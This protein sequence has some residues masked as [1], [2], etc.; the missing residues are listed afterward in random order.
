MRRVPPSLQREQAQ[1]EGPPSGLQRRSKTLAEVRFIA[2][3]LPSKFLTIFSFQTLAL[4]L[5]RSRLRPPSPSSLPT[6]AA[7]RCLMLPLA[8]SHALWCPLPVSRL[9]VPSLAVS[10]ALAPSLAVSGAPSPSLVH[11]RRP[12]SSLVPCRRTSCPLP[13][14]R[15][16]TPSRAVPRRPSRSG[17]VSGYLWCFLVPSRRLSSSLVPPHC[18]S[19][20]L[21]HRRAPSCPLVAR[22]AP[23]SPVVPRR[24]P[25]LSILHSCRP[26]LSLSTWCCLLHPLADTFYSLIPGARRHHKGPRPAKRP[27]QKQRAKQWMQRRE[28]LFTTTPSTGMGSGPQSTDTFQQLPTERSRDNRTSEEKDAVLEWVSFS[29]SFSFSRE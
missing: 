21:V 6:H 17:A 9:L 15:P 23:S 7:L 27:M 22:R 18:L 20:P 19:C 12:S 28:L 24:A 2:H 13:V 14:S 4:A 10:L 29:F 11:S 16:L 1:A 3:L 25:S 26:A 5:S 8:V